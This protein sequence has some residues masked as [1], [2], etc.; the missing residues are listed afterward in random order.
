[1]LITKDS[2]E[3]NPIVEDVLEG[4]LTKTIEITESTTFK[5]ANPDPITLKFNGE[6]VELTQVSG[7]EYYTY[8]ATPQ[9]SSAKSKDST[10]SSSSIDST[11][12]E[13]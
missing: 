12:S 10:T 7:T 2:D 9:T 1:V 3:D 6:E 8:T 13:E 4:P 11:E 5:T